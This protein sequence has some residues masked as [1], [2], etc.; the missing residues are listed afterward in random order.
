MP[1]PD[2]PLTEREKRLLRR[3]AEDKTDAEIAV[4]IGGTAKQIAAQ[5]ERLLDRLGIVSDGEIKDAAKSLARWPYRK[6]KLTR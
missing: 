2:P 4:R 5:R 1:D 6:S 3:I